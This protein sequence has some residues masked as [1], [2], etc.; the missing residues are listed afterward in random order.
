L[1][2]EITGVNL[3]E[4]AVHVYVRRLNSLSPEKVTRKSFLKSIH[5][6]VAFTALVQYNVDYFVVLANILGGCRHDLVDDLTEEHDVSTR[7]LS[8]TRNK[9]CD[10]LFVLNQDVRCSVKNNDNDQVPHEISSKSITSICCSRFA[11]RC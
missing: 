5:L 3:L 1:K 6:V 9:L 10:C 7:V 2:V 8:Y 11:T 4:L